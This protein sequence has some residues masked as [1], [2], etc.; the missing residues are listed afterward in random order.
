MGGA[1]TQEV[2]EIVRWNQR[3]EEVQTPI[4]RFAAVFLN[5]RPHIYPEERKRVNESLRSFI[6]YYYYYYYYYTSRYRYHYRTTTTYYV[7]YK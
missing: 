3:E 7:L 2:E 4:Y 5:D 6:Y 1:K